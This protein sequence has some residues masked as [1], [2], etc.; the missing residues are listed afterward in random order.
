MFSE[1]NLN[2]IVYSGSPYVS[3]PVTITHDNKTIIFL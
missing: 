3:V 1:Y 2:T